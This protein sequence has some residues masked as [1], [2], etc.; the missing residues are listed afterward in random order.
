M[1]KKNRKMSQGRLVDFPK[2]SSVPY[3]PLSNYEM[4]SEATDLIPYELAKKYSI[5]PVSREGN[6]VSIVMENPFDEEAVKVVEKF[7][8]CVVRRFVGT[9]KEIADAIASCMT[10]GTKTP[11]PVRSKEPDE[12]LAIAKDEF[13][14]DGA[15]PPLKDAPWDG[16][17]ERRSAFRFKCSLDVHFP[18][19]TSYIKSKTIDISYT[20]IGLMSKNP[21]PVGTYLSVRIDIPGKALSFPVALLVL[22]VRSHRIDAENFCIGGKI[23]EEDSE[24]IRRFVKHFSANGEIDEP[25]YKGLDKRKYARY[26]A[27]TDLWFPVNGSYEKATLQDISDCGFSFRSKTGIPVGSYLPVE[28]GYIKDISNHPLV[29]VTEVARATTVEGGYVDIGV[30]WI[31]IHKNGSDMEKLIRYAGKHLHK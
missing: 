6:I 19:K 16:K 8:G 13:R 4:T 11:A 31:N 26:K 24:D 17:T 9:H 1:A 22:V 25:S 20:G 12:S 14:E 3:L 28:I 21:I 7:T 29:W 5:V 30:K 18:N 27:D 23:L 15:G 2:T 10:I